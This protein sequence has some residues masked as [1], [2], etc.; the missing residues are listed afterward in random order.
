MDSSNVI[1]QA[2]CRGTKRPRAPTGKQTSG[3]TVSSLPA[4]NR[5]VARTC[6]HPDCGKNPYFGWYG[7]KAIFCVAHKEEGELQPRVTYGERQAVTTFTSIPQL[8][9]DT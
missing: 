6:R 1:D 7:Q 5:R 8:L 2:G 3:R 4:A 9:E